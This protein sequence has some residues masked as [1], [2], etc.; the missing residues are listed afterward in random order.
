MEMEKTKISLTLLVIF[1]LAVFSFYVQP[2]NATTILTKTWFGSAKIEDSFYYYATGHKLIVCTTDTSTTPDTVQFRVFNSDTL[3]SLANATSAIADALSCNNQKASGQTDGNNMICSDGAIGCFLV[4]LDTFGTQGITIAKFNLDTYTI[5]TY[6]NTTWTSSALGKPLAIV[7]S[8][9]YFTNAGGAMPVGLW[10]MNI[11]TP[12]DGDATNDAVSLQRLDPSAPSLPQGGCYDSGS[13]LISTLTGGNVVGKITVATGTYTSLGTNL[14]SIVNDVTCISGS[15][16]WASIA[17]GFVKKVNVSSG[18]LQATISLSASN[19][20]VKHGTQL[21]VAHSTTNINGYDLTSLALVATYSGLSGSTVILLNGNSTSFYTLNSNE[22]I[23][24]YNGLPDD[25]S[26]NPPPPDEGSAFCQIPANENLLRCRLEEQG[27]AMGGFQGQ[28]NPFNPIN[29]TNSIFVSALGLENDDVKTNGVGYI[30]LAVALVIIN[31]MF[32]LV[33]AV[34]S[35]KNV[36]IP[37]PLWIML[38]ISLAVIAGFV[39]MG[40]TDAT[41]LII[42]IVALVALASPRIVQL[43]QARGAS[44]ES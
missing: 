7:G 16:Y 12:F 6:T 37:D 23:D 8:L 41:F 1:L 19:D 14:V 13:G 26:S 43:I 29:G 33:L 30:L 5:S 22:K 39:V 25:G 35:G 44:G 18:T 9:L 4:A 27:G 15:S 38:I 31:L 17:G 24:L 2:A 21:L 3:V 34:A 40:I 10:S 20:V 42:S 11:I 32:V 36:S 28:S